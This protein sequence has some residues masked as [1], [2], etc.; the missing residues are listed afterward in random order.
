LDDQV[1]GI[2]AN[3]TALQSHTDAWRHHTKQADDRLEAEW[4]KIVQQHNEMIVDNR[5]RFRAWDVSMWVGLVVSAAVV[6]FF[7][8]VGWLFRPIQDTSDVRRLEHRL[9][10]L[11][12]GLQ[13]LG[14]P[15]KDE[16][17]HDNDK[18]TCTQRQSLKSLF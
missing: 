8:F 10:R 2:L 11:E 5:A 4:K 12:R 9:T 14:T 7:C 17:K 13:S 15:I 6:L 16:K 18:Y 1:A 3:W